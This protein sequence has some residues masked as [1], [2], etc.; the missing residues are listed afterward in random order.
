MLATIGISGYSQSLVLVYNGK[1]HTGVDTLQVDSINPA[2]GLMK[3]VIDVKN[4][5]SREVEVKV[6]KNPLS[7]LAGSQNTFCWG[8]NCYSELITESQYQVIIPGNSINRTFLAEYVPSGNKSGKSIFEFQFYEVLNATNQVKV[9]VKFN[10]G[11]TGIYELQ[12]EEYLTVHDAQNT[13]VIR[14]SYNLTKESHFV[15]RNL[16]GLQI[17][18]ITLP[19]GCL[20]IKLPFNLKPGIYIYSLTRSDK[21]ILNKKFLIF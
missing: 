19:V 14:I 15:V 4:T 1:E 10:E 18:Q 16:S 3:A 21:I 13:G 2:L 12:S 9:I 11:I 8:T 6:K 20:T 17:G 7:V 5:G